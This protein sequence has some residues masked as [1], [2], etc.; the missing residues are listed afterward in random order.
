MGLLD[1]IKEAASRVVEKVAEKKFESRR[2]VKVG[3]VGARF[4]E[5][6]KD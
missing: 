1:R 5:E 3:L 6:V 2:I 4:D